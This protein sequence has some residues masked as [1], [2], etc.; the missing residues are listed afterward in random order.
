MKKIVLSLSIL[1]ATSL[2]INAQAVD[3]HA[4]HDHANTK[5]AAPAVVTAA[6]FEKTVID[7]GKIPQNKPV[8]VDFKYKNITKSPLVCESA[9]GSCGC[10]VPAKPEKPTMPGK[11]DMISATYNAASMGAFTKTVTVKF[12]GVDTPVVL[13]IKGEVVAAN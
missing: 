12:A 1:F 10:T 13:E 6:K 2:A 11:S 8:T 3:L 7:M 5:V 9:T 4:G